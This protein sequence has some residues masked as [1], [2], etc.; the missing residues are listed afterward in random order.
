M[1]V[2][3]L[4]VI[5]LFL[6]SLVG[7]FGG[8]HKIH[9][10]ISTLLCLM[11]PASIV[12]SIKHDPH[13]LA[14]R[15]RVEHESKLVEWINLG[16]SVNPLLKEYYFKYPSRFTFPYSNSEAVIEGFATY[17]HQHGIPLVNGKIV[18]P[19]GDPVLFVIATNATNYFKF[20]ARNNPLYGTTRVGSSTVSVGLLLDK[21]NRLETR[22]SE[23]WSMENGLGTNSIN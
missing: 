22:S 8:P 10:G 20:K 7:I 19:W 1:L 12:Y 6:Y 13:E 9:A 2:N 11:S 14:E 5:I 15:Q 18:D 21:P 4:F 16:K 23:Q 3:A 17:A